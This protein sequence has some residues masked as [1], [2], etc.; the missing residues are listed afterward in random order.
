MKNL[1]VF[2]VFLTLVMGCS[3]STMTTYYIK[4]ETSETLYNVVSAPV[5]S[6]EGSEFCAHG[7][8]APGERSNHISTE[9]AQIDVAWNYSDGSIDTVE[10]PFSL[11]EGEVN[12]LIIID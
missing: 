2:F 6:T 4:N 1:L 9:Y 11:D 3:K 12:P 5:G 7:N 8:L 10:E